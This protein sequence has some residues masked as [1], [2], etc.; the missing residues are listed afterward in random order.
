[1]VRRLF[2]VLAVDVVLW[3][4]LRSGRLAIGLS[5]LRSRGQSRSFD[6]RNADNEM[7]VIELLGQRQIESHSYRPCNRYRKAA[8]L[9][10]A[11]LSCRCGH[12]S[13]IASRASALPDPTKYR[14]VWVPSRSSEFGQCR[15]PQGR[16]RP[17]SIIARPASANAMICANGSGEPSSIIVT[18]R[19]QWILEITAASETAEVL[20]ASLSR[21]V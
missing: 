1:M 2:T 10:R 14:W 7:S 4:V 11:E 12:S 13:P 18:R 15:P 17:S 6:Q 20:V 5:P 16:D 21:S 8:G 9:E 19:A 3:V